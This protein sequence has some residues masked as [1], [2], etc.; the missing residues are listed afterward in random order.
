MV[1]ARLGVTVVPIRLEG[2]DRVLHHTWRFPARGPVS[3]TFGPAI[4]LEGND[5]AALAH[6]LEEAVR[7]LGAT[8]RVKPVMT[9]KS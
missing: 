4:L 3:V 7:Q 5:Y 1:A 6:R 8:N 2:L 9:A